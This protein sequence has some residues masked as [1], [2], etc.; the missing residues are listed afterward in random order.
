MLTTMPFCD[1]NK[2]ADKFI[3][4]LAF[5]SNL[6]ASE[7]DSEIYTSSNLGPALLA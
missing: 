7:L 3:F 2:A 1:V 4:V 6:H 5:L